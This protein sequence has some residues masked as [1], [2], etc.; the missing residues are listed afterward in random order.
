[1]NIL[2]TTETRRA[3]STFYPTPE[4][5]AEELTAGYDWET[6]Q[7]VLEPSA[8][9]GDLARKAGYRMYQKRMGY[10]PYDEH[11]RKEAITSTD[12]DCIEIDPTLRAI[13]EGQGFRVVHNDFLTFETQ[14]RYD[15]I[16]MNPPFDQ[17]AEHLLKAL[18]LQSHG[19][20]IACILN[21]ETLRNPYTA[22][23][24]RLVKELMAH[25]AEITYK[26]RA[27][28]DAER[29]TNVDIAIIRVELP[30][31]K[32][33]SSIMDEMRKA[34]TYKAQEIPSQYAEMV[35]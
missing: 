4:S 12:I 20:K 23:R 32:R 28:T 6:V 9:K 30:K 17:G 31:V 3:K 25:G 18:E 7:S 24:Q 8:G 2:R 1:M 5:L 27:F 19:G 21:A 15:L 10:A 33:D 13:L 35:R 34:P 29:R 26:E 22:A 16:L 14:K 11:S